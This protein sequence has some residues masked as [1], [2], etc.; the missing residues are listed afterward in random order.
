MQ[1]HFSPMYQV[2]FDWRLKQKNN[3]KI[4]LIFKPKFLWNKTLLRPN[5]NQME[6]AHYEHEQT[7]QPKAL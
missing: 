2:T 4:V 1:R 6:W 3:K 5:K 7:I